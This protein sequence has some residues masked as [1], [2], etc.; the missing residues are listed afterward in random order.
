MKRAVVLLVLLLLVTT[1]ILYVG[2]SSHQSFSKAVAIACTND[3]ALRVL[4][5]EG[6]SRQVWPSK[7]INDSVYQFQNIQYT[8]G[9]GLINTIDIP[10]TFQ[11]ESI[12]AQLFVEETTPDSSRITIAVSQHLSMNPVERIKS[13]FRF[14]KLK[15]EVEALVTEVA[16]KLNGEEIV[17]GISVQMSRVT[18]STMISMRKILDHYP[19]TNEVYEMID[20]IRNYIAANGGTETSAPMLNVFEEDKNTWL[21]MVALPTTTAVTGT[22]TF[23]LKRMLANGFI[24]VSEVQGGNET[25]K[26]AENALRQYVTDHQKTSPAIPFQMLVTDRRAEPDTTKWKT[27]LYYPVMY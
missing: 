7:K 22:E 6:K 5:N 8:V 25:I 16:N 21:V 18:D 1:G 26:K 24:L 11:Q 4:V 15:K 10:V 20:A 2:I 23:V 14:Q 12:A 19:S 17:Y 27:K 9:K 13:Y 3:G